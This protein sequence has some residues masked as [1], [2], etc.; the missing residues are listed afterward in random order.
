MPYPNTADL[1]SLLRLLVDRNVEFIV[2]GGAAV[3]LHGGMLTTN[4]LDIVPRRSTDNVARLKSA[5]DE[6]DAIVREPGE[7]RLRPEAELFAAADQL[8]LRTTRGPLDVLAKLHDGRGY[9][10]LL[11]HCDVFTPGEP[12]EPGVGPTQV[13]ETA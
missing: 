10:E 13:P 12:G 8:L 4:D 11:P 5:L 3:V 1:A 2:V 7:R 9:E 6:L